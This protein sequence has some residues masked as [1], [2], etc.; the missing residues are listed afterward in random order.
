MHELCPNT[1]R[2]RHYDM[3]LQT[4]LWIKGKVKWIT[5]LKSSTEVVFFNVVLSLSGSLFR[6]LLG[7]VRVVFHICMQFS[8]I[9]ERNLEIAPNN[10]G[11]ECWGQTTKQQERIISDIFYSTYVLR[12]KFFIVQGKD[13]R[14][15][16]FT[17]KI[18]NLWDISNIK[19][20]IKC[21]Q[22]HLSAT[23]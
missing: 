18:M 6:S 7:C 4:S 2:T 12:N 9:R 5:A 1:Q 22:D 19:F 15:A 14:T 21:D 8:R 3:R 23:R 17:V 16:F 13:I 10:T 11:E 20:K